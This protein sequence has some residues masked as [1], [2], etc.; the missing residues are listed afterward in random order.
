MEA[1]IENLYRHVAFLTSIYPYRNYKNIESLQKAAAY[2]EVEMKE[3]GLPTT[4]QQWEAKGNTYEN[5]FA[6]Y[7]PKKTKR[8]IIG[9]H[10]DVYKESAGADDNASSVAGLME[11]ARMLTE[12]SLNLDYGIDFVFFCLEEPPFFKTDKMGSYIH[13]NSI[14]DTDKD[15]IG[16]I[17]LEMI[18][19]YREEKQISKDDSLYKNQL[20]VSWIKRYDAFNKKISQLLKA[21][22]KMDSRRLS[23]ANDYLNNCPSDHRNYWP[24]HIPAVMVI[25]TGGHGNPHYHTNTD[26]IETL[27]FEIMR[28]AVGSIGY[29]LFNFSE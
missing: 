16:M 29:T 11:I 3:I 20:I 8:F 4:R 18:G 13:A 28:E 27:D 15:Y 12:I 21:N 5:I 17:A 9:A 7:Q 14:A 22:G 25:G 1:N 19:Y 26:T 24:F 6:Q 2:I 10:Y 23:Y